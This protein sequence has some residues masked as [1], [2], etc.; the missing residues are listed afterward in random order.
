MLVFWRER[1]VLLS[2]PKT[3]TTALEGALHGRASLVTRMAPTLKHL[4]FTGYRT[5][6]L[7]LLEAA[8]ARDF[9]SVAVVRHPV[10]WLSSWY[11]YRQREE[12]AGQPNSTRGLTFDDFVRDYASDA[13]PPHAAVGSQAKFVRTVRGRIGV[14]HLFRY[15]EPER[16]L[17][18]LEERL[19][20]LPPL[21]RANVSPVLETPLSAEGEALL[22]AARPEEFEVWEAA[23]R[24]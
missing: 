23:G 19:G 1:L 21:P 15:E 18:F 13:P 24:R 5:L 17:A 2:V 11:R 3:G 20:P 6:V 12:I 14:D 22:R 4:P 8:G 16:L 9:R 7:P 10:S